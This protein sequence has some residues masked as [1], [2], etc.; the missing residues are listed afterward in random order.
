MS[1]GD[2]FKSAWN[3]ASDK[4]RNAVGAL[5][6]GAKDATNW[7]ENTVSQ[8]VDKAKQA[9]NWTAN[10]TTEV[11][12]WAKDT[13]DSGKEKLEEV[14]QKAVQAYDEGKK[15]LEQGKNWAKDKATTTSKAVQETYQNIKKKFTDTVAGVAIVTC[16][17][18]RV[19]ENF[20]YQNVAAKVTS[21]IGS[22]TRHFVPEDVKVTFSDENFSKWTG[23]LSVEDSQNI[24]ETV[25]GKTISKDDIKALFTDPNKAKAILMKDKEIHTVFRGILNTNTP[26]SP[27]EALDSG[28]WQELTKG[29]AVFHAS[30]T[31]GNRKFVSIDG[32]REV[33]FTPDGTIDQSNEFMG[34]FNFFHPTEYPL[35]HILTDVDPYAEYGN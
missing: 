8:G 7:A 34:T 28:Q 4:A 13:Y 22:A 2:S 11:K 16:K 24:Y 30:L 32:Y 35:S 33:I 17:Y 12:Q 23:G 10:K 26:S 1:W 29:E 6:T 15:K 5:A 18:E 21:L 14:K 20:V 27:E 25:T 31:R 9:A 3:D 19:T